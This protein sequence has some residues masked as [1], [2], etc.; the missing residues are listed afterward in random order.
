LPKWNSQRRERAAEY[1]RLLTAADC[2]VN[3]PHEPSWSKAVCH[4][5]VVRS[6]DR[7]GL[8][9]HLHK[10]GISTGIH[11]PIPLHLQKAYASLGYRA[12]DFPVAEKAAA[13]VVSLPMYPQLTS[14]QQARI[15]FEVAAF[16]S[17]S[18]R[19]CVEAETVSVG[20]ESGAIS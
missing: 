12:G 14:Q 3:P 6:Q 11:Y 9:I 15:V 8:M 13:E 18:V 4:L 19:K 5:Y 17:T 20:A 7:E 1:R 2:G 10:A 16:T